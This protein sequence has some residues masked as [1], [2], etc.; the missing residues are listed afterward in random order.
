MRKFCCGV[1][2][3]SRTPIEGYW[4]DMVYDSIEELKKD[5][6]C[7]VECGIV[8]LDFDKKLSY[9]SMK[10]IK[11]HEPLSMKNALRYYGQDN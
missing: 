4:D 1:V 11:W 8:E 6:M 3:K 7:W 2:F 5:T 10:L 9:K